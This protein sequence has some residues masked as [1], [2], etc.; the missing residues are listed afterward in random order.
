VSRWLLL[1]DC[2][3]KHGITNRGEIA[4]HAGQL[5]QRGV[6]TS[7]FGV[8]A[9][10]DERLL[11]DMAHEGGANFYFIE[12]A[13]QIPGILTGELGEALEVT[14]RGASLVVRPNGGE[15][16][17]VLNRFRSRQ[18]ADLGELRVEL[19][20]LVSDQT[21]DVV[22]E[23]RFP[24]GEIGAAAGVSVD[25][26][27]ADE[28]APGA[29]SAL[30]WTYATHAENDVQ[31]RNREVDRAVAQV[32]VARA[33]AEATEANRNDRLDRAR[34]VL[35]ATANRIGGYAGDDA[36]LRGLVRALG[37]DV[38]TCAE[39]LMSPMALKASLYVAESSA[40]GRDSL[41]RA[42]RG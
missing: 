14:M 28:L 4:H 30:R 9:D 41:N 17:E 15:R 21:L 1:T 11:R 19:G 39:T 27:S 20:D 35:E 2:I 36:E 13:A 6:V 42:R 23:V 33:R 31:P 37:R 38:A 32:Y 7:T 40:K 3:A 24:R 22:L 25:L 18:V 12:G 5:R 16:V 29:T 26:Q 34:E 8:G 10:F